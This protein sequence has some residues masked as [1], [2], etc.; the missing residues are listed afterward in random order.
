MRI[1]VVLPAPFGP[2]SATALP[3]SA[4]HVT[5]SRARVLPKRLL[6][7][8]TSSAAGM[9]WRL[10]QVLDEVADHHRPHPLVQLVARLEGNPR[11]GD[12]RSQHHAYPPARPDDGA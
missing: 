5:P 11:G 2:S 1:N 10:L 8:S 4:A 7:C 6:R 12:R 9:R 3:A